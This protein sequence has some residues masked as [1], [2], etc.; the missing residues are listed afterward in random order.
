M[1]VW[2]Y[3]DY[4]SRELA[5]S[6]YTHYRSKLLRFERVHGT[7]PIGSITSPVLFEYLYGR[8]GV[9][10]DCGIRNGSQH[11]TAIQNMLN[12]ATLRGLC[13]AVSVP[14]SP[15]GSRPEERDWTRYSADEMLLLQDSMPCPRSRIIVAICTN[16]AMRIDDIFKM[17]LKYV[18]LSTNDLRVKIHKSKM[19]DTKPVTLD[20]EHELRRYMVWYAETC[21]VSERD[22]VYLVPGSKK[23][24]WVGG[25]PGSG[26]VPDP[27]RPVSYNWAY[28]RLRATMDAQR[29]PYE[30]GEAWHMLRR[31]VARLYFD[32]AVED[33]YDRAL[34]MTQAL[35]NHKDVTTTEKYLGL[36]IETLK[37]DQSLKGRAFLTRG[38]E[39]V[40]SI[41][42]ARRLP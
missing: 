17:R 30:Q 4:A 14:K 25:G 7:T 32:T 21:G 16:T 8:H 35:L 6:T 41:D 11:R 33:G 26:Y 23:V 5:F 40:L 18:R 39:N 15:G 37:R 31:S 13:P 1:A 3:L 36:T 28:K 22:D 38:R 2:D 42:D 12:Y 27:E 34:R 10:R 29:L 20:L 9:T 19:W 24:G